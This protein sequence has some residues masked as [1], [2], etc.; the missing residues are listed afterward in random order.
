MVEGPYQSAKTQVSKSNLTDKIIVRLANGLDAIE[1]ED[2]IDVISICGMGG[3]LIRDILEAGR[4][5]SFN[6]KERLVLQPNI[7]EPTLRRRLMANDYSIVDETIV[8]ENRKLYEIIVAEKQSNPFLIR[9][10]NYYLGQ[11]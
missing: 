10:E 6:R 5:K 7:G 2:Q 11:F 8:E 1:P 4:K 3:T 9:T